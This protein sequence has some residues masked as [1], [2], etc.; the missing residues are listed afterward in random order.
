MLGHF[1][2]YICLAKPLRFV[3]LTMCSIISQVACCSILRKGGRG[4]FFFSNYFKGT[5]QPGF[6]CLWLWAL[7]S[8]LYPERGSGLPLEYHF[9]GGPLNGPFQGKPRIPA[10]LDSRSNA[11][12]LFNAAGRG[13]ARRAI[14][15]SLYVLGLTPLGRPTTP[16][17]RTKGL[18]V[19]GTHSTRARLVMDQRALL[20][21]GV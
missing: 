10:Y 1:L 5:T 20:I 17:H 16:D 19:V 4:F 6:L 18:C 11:L 15:L 2:R 3:R 12:G 21:S 13:T 7:A 8:S 14:S 9:S